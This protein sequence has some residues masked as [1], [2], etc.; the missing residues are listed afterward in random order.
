MPIAT[1]GG[2]LRRGITEIS[3]EAGSGE[4]L[5]YIILVLLNYL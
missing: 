5:V 2:I 4:L 1:G 3:G